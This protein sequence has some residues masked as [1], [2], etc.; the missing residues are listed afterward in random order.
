MQNHHCIANELSNELALFL[1]LLYIYV[2]DGWIVWDWEAHFRNYRRYVIQ[3]LELTTQFPSHGLTQAKVH[4]LAKWIAVS[5]NQTAMACVA[6]E[7]H[8]H[9]TMAPIF[10]QLYSPVKIQNKI[11]F[12]PM[13]N[14]CWK[15][16]YHLSAPKV[17]E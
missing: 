3:C 5:G 1:S 8:D 9:Y 15:L 11:V 16:F 4:S 2:Y 10:T 17:C 7:A 14:T 12:T 13:L 6:I